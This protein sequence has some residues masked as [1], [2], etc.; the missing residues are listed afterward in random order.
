MLEHLGEVEA[1]RR[2]AQAVADFDG[3][4]AVLGTDGITQTANWKVVN[5]H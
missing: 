1:A 2:I 5:G 3:D 4:V